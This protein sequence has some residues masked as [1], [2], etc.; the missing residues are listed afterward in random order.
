MQPSWLGVPQCCNQQDRQY[1]AHEQW[2]QQTLILWGLDQNNCPAS[3]CARASVLTAAAGCCRTAFRQQASMSE[4]DGR[5]IPGCHPHSCRAVR[6]RTT[7]SLCNRVIARP[8]HQSGK[9]STTI[10][11][12]VLM[13]CSTTA[14][15]R[16]R[17]GSGRKSVVCFF[18]A[19]GSSH[20]KWCGFD[21]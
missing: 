19:D 9:R 2:K 5:P 10:G 3:R 1:M 15:A 12:P 8:A 21:R 11:D 16:K 7:S 18:P 17:A 6:V 20:V 14:G 13:F 4:G